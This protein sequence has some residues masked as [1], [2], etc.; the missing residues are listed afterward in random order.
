MSSIERY[1]PSPRITNCSSPRSMYP[2]PTF[3]LLRSSALSTCPSV[4]RCAASRSGASTTWY[5]RF[6]PPKALISIARH[7]A[8]ARR[9]L[10]VE[11]GAKLHRRVPVASQHELVDLSDPVNGGHLGP[12]EL[13]GNIRFDAAQALRH[14]L[15]REPHVYPVFED[16]RHRRDAL[17]RDRP[18]LRETREPVEPELDRP[19]DVLLH[20]FG[21]EALRV[22]EHLHL[23]VGDVGH[24]V[25]GQ[26]A[27]RDGGGEHHHRRNH[28]HGDTKADRESDDGVEH[29]AKPRSG[30]VVVVVTAA[31]RS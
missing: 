23:R 21:R 4:S 14:Q 25:D 8:Q 17:A 1:C 29:V 5:W 11:H 20:L 24:H 30:V 28:Q 15:P 7:A 2:P 18:D 12:A 9:D 22:G 10:P 16:H 26:R 13:P 27:H 19:G 31:A 6:A 3:T